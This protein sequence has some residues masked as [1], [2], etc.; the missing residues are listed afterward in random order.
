MTA[1]I[2][3]LILSGHLGAGKTTVLNQLLAS[4]G[5]RIGVIINDF[6]SVNVDAG[7]VAGQIDDPVS[8]TGGCLCCI[9]DPDQLESALRKLSAPALALDVI[10]IEGSGVAEPPALIHIVLST[11][12]KR[13]RFAGLVEVVDAAHVAQAEADGWDLRTHVRAAAMV[14][15]T[16]TDLIQDS[17]EE[18]FLR[19]RITEA[20]PHAT[21]VNAPHG[22]VD[23]RLFF[24]A[25]APR[26]PAD[27]Q[28]A[29]WEPGELPGHGQPR[30]GEHHQEQQHQHHRAVS[31][32][33]SRPHRPRGSCGCP[34]RPTARGLPAQRCG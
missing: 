19:R 5:A 14:L 27:G 18:D 11:T 6:G 25:A 4:G 21:I 2:P 7:L 17:S 30:H 29:L 16:K 31:L 22:L 9:E 33:T 1:P 24:D 15:L 20:N 23:P 12:V 26:E 32:E 28:L 34:A 8:I 10:V 3:V 13:V